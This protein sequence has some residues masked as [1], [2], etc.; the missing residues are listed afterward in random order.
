MSIKKFVYSVPLTMLLFDISSATSLKDVVKHTIISNQDVYSK[1]LN[2]KAFEKYVDEQKG[3]YYPKIDLSAS[4]EKI[5][6][7]RKSSG[8]STN[9]TRTGHNIQVDLEQLIYDGGLTPARV[10]EAKYRFMAN[11]Y[12]NSDDIENIILDGVNAYLN[13]VKFQERMKISKENLKVH[14]QYLKIAQETEKINGS[15]LD[16]VQTKAEIHNAKNNLLSEMNNYNIAKSS[17]DK[18]VGIRVLGDICRPVVNESDLLASFDE[19]KKDVLSSNYKIKEQMEVLKEQKEKLGQKDSNFLPTVKLK[20]KALK[21]KDL[22][23]DDTKTDRL[24]GKIELRYNLF[25]GLSDSKASEKEKLF[26]KE[27]RAKLDVVRK[28][29]LD[30]LESAYNTYQTSKKQIV[31]LE[32]FIEENKQII[33]IYNDQFDS[34]TRNF[35]DVLNVNT[36]LYNSKILLI[37]TEFEMYKAY[38]EILQLKSSLQKSIA[39]SKRQVCDI[40]YSPKERLKLQENFENKEKA[41]GLDEEEKALD[42]VEL[43]KKLKQEEKELGLDDGKD[44]SLNEKKFEQKM[45]EKKNSNE[46]LNSEKKLYT[47][48]LG[49]YGS[50][51]RVERD[52]E[53]TKSYLEGKEKMIIVPTSKGNYVLGVGS[54]PNKEKAKYLKSVLEAKYPGS[55]FK[56]NKKAI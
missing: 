26:L 21:D 8:V 24:S 16:R 50:K 2:N 44:L 7:K 22:I 53:K 43:E 49:T 32:Q 15:I 47:L 34:G 33:D 4:L 48:Y 38:F 52:L 45:I 19:L 54:I 11:K 14:N 5:K 30:R 37:N 6:D 27:T 28:N 25:N 56:K 39:T 20:L 12:K 29:I 31:E 18:N 46:T 36:D 40:S 13:M 3:G 10:K 41:L 1:S 55:Y 17:F 23:V 9:D 35:I 51:E 42:D